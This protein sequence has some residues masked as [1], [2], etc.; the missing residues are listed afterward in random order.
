LFSS[1]LYLISIFQHPKGITPNLA[2][3][4]DFR[5]KARQLDFD[6]SYLVPIQYRNHHGYLEVL[7]ERMVRDVKKIDE[8]LKDMENF[9]IENE[10]FSAN[11]EGPIYETSIDSRQTNVKKVN[12][13]AN[14]DDD[15]QKSLNNGLD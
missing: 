6:S 5:K 9:S 8:L 2:R 12:I 10:N 3:G 7:R 11:N 15:E 4:M 1:Y 13:P 14:L